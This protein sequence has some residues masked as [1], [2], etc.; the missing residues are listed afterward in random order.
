MVLAANTEP[1][2]ESAIAL[3]VVVSGVIKQSATLADELHQPASRVVIALVRAQV[4]GE[5]IDPFGENSDLDL[6]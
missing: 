3:N 1:S 4:L 5:V 2:D 6:G